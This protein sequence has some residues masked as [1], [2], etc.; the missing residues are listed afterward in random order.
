[1]LKTLLNVI[2]QKNRNFSSNIYR[3]TKQFNL[4]KWILVGSST[5]LIG[6]V[7]YDGIVKDFEKT[8]GIQRFLRC[9]KIAVIISADYS[10][11]LHNLDEDSEEYDTVSHLTLFLLKFDI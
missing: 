9:L 10:W 5:G 3:G 8:G 7:I 1:M 11:N 2:F 4:K 6:T